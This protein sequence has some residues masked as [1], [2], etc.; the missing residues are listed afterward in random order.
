[1]KINKNI[2]NQRV[3]MELNENCW[4]SLKINEN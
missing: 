3:S 2:E 4:N 1:M